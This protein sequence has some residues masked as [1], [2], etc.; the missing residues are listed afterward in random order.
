MHSRSNQDPVAAAL[1]IAASRVVDAIA[2]VSAAN[3]VVLIDGRSGAGKTTLARLLA[4]RWPLAGRPQS[5][6]MDSLY[7]GWNGL[8]AGIERALDG[9]LRPHGRGRIGIWHRWDWAQGADAES[10]AVDPAL[11]VILEGCGA[12]TPQTAPI[13]DVLV[14]VESPDAARK[15]RALQRDGD[16]FRPHWDRWAAQEQR[17][18][19]R[20]DPRGLATVQVRIP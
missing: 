9:I 2:G 5:I 8:D 16:A 14:W 20:D 3:P 6:A 10:H 18:L 12:I 13:A 4:E 7:P 15:S 19:D 17:H 11:G 1:D